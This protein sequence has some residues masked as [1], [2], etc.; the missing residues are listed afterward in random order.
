MRALAQPMSGSP[1][2]RQIPHASQSHHV[3]SVHVRRAP[4]AQRPASLQVCCQAVATGSPPVKE[5][6]SIAN[7]ATKGKSKKISPEVATVLY[8]DM[9]LGRE[10]EEMCAQMYYRGKMFGF[11]H[12]YSGQEAVSTGIIKVCCQRLHSS[13]LPPSALAVSIQGLFDLTCSKRITCP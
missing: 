5:G 3:Q 11:V 12:L 9:V 6:T 2:S 4:R 8:R 1:G 10:F 13:C 7:G